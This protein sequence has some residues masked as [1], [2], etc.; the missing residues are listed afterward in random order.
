MRYFQPERDDRVSLKGLLLALDASPVSLKRDLVRG[1]GRTG[2]LAVHGRLGH[3]YPDGDGYLLCIVAADE[4]DQSAR[5]WSN[6]K[7]RLG[8][9]QLRQDGDAEGTLRLDRLPTPHEA[10]L[11]REA[12]GV[13]RKRQL[14]AEAKASLASRFSQNPT[15]RPSNDNAFI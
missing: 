6:V 11:V 2:D 13:K 15:G 4:L 1:E 7:Q 3:I 8:F 9:C 5:R 12:L 14:S 10:A